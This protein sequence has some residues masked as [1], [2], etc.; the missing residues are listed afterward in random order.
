MDTLTVLK[1]AN[2]MAIYIGVL[3]LVFGFIWKFIS[4]E[5]TFDPGEYYPDEKLFYRFYSKYLKDL[6]CDF[7]VNPNPKRRDIALIRTSLP[8]NLTDTDLLRLKRYIPQL[9][10][11]VFVQEPLERYTTVAFQK[12]SDIYWGDIRHKILWFFF[13]KLYKE[14]SYEAKETPPEFV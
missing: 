11:C 13:C 8:H 3:S 6:H 7:G 4:F 9:E 14:Y 1:A 5:K 2:I 10:E 12:S